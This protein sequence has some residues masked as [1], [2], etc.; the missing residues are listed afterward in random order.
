MRVQHDTPHT[1]TNHPYAATE[2]HIR[3]IQAK[4]TKLVE[5]QIE[6][7]KQLITAVAREHSRGTITWTEL[8]RVYEHVIREGALP[9]WHQRW[10]EELPYTAHH[11]KQMTAIHETEEWSGIGMNVHLDPHRP[12]KGAHVV[13]VLYNE[14]HEPIYVGSTQT[15]TSRM[16]CHRKDK[17]W[18]SWHAYRCNDRA[19]AYEVESRFLRQYKPTLNKQGARVAS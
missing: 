16:S 6:A 5:T 19:H 17:T 18:V 13:Y 10:Q 9:G 14:H 1:T 7:E 12:P 4:R 15:F 3:L 11:M 8:L 2:Q